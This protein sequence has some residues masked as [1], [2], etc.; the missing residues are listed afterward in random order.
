MEKLPLYKLVVGGDGSVD[1]VALVDEPAIEVYWQKFGKDKP[2]PEPLK[3]TATDTEQR[4]LSG[5]LMIPDKPIF[6]KANEAVKSD[7]YVFF[8]TPTIKDLMISF[9][10]NGNGRN[11]NLMHSDKHQVPTVYMIESFQIDSTR[12]I[13]APEGFSD[14]PEGAWFG[15]YKVDDDTLWNEFISTGKFRGFSVEGFFEYADPEEEEQE[16]MA[17]LIESV[18]MLGQVVD[19]ISKAKKKAA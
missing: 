15:S 13:L 7:H 16:D 12:G 6:R 2:S 4:I 8:D 10:K 11:V 14:L 1:F 9:H 3:F 19:Y 17:E 18:E 5:P